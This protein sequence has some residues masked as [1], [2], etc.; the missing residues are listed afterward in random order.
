MNAYVSFLILSTYLYMSIIG[1]IFPSRK[2]LWSPNLQFLK[3]W[4]FWME[5]YTEIVSQN[6]VIKVALIQ[7]DL[8]PY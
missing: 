7:F 8:Y 5:V 3:K 6:E 2:L 4:P 1:W